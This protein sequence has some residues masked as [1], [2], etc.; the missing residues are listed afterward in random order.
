MRYLNANRLTACAAL[1]AWSLLTPAACWAQAVPSPA[2]VMPPSL[3]PVQAVNL[4]TAD[5]SAAFG[6]KW[7]WMD[8]KI[9]DVPPMQG[10]M[11]HYKSTYS[12][13]P[14][15]HTARFDD[16][17]WPVIEPKDL[18]ARRGGGGVAFVWYR[19]NLTIPAKIG[20]STPP[21]RRRC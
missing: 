4:M 16:S 1:A 18:S 2:P 20:D 6:A 3:P 10:A 17:S 9:V 11:P 8:V 12:I 13:E 7:K 14:R 5:G 21:T 19:T 15:A